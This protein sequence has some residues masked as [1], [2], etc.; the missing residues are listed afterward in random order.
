MEE[1]QENHAH[2]LLIRQHTWVFQEVGNNALLIF[3]ETN[4]GEKREFNDYMN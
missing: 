4:S 2:S 3:Q 1:L